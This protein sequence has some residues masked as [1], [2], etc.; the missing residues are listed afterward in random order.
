MKLHKSVLTFASTLLLAML[1]YA[2]TAIEFPVT[3]RD[4]LLAASQIRDQIAGLCA[5]D[6]AAWIKIML[7]PNQI[8]FLCF[9]LAAHAVMDVARRLLSCVRRREEASDVSH[10]VTRRQ[11]SSR[12]G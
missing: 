1:W 11:P 7:W 3:M 5:K 8:V 10:T 2:C 9:A 12:W 6:S 4:I